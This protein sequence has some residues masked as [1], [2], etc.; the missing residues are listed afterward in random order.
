MG[1]TLEDI[2]RACGVSV[3]TVD[4]AMNNKPRISPTTKENILR[5]ANE[6]G[7]RPD[8]LARSLVKG[9]S[10]SIGVV[11]FEIRNRF[12]AQ[13]VN[14]IEMQAK[15][16][17]YFVYITLHEEDPALE[18]RLVNNLVDRR[19]DGIVICPVGKG[20]A[21][22]RFIEHLAV[23]VITI[24]NRISD[25]VPCVGIDEAAAAR[26]AARLILNRGYRNLVFV[27]PSLEN[28]E[29]ENLF[30]H[31][32]RLAG[33]LEAMSGCEDAR[34]SIIDHWDYLHHVQ[35]MIGQG[36]S[37]TAFFCS[38]DTFALEILKMARESGRSVPEDFGLMGFDGIDTLEYVTPSLATVAVP[39][40]KIGA[41]AVDLLLDQIEGR[42]FDSESL[43]PYH[44]VEGN[45]LKG[46]MSV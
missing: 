46:R 17:D 34:Y 33:F 12:F 19:I 14:A 5:T 30:S 23:P 13:L 45:S 22:D 8:L 42:V 31:E 26:D 1:V 18:T 2:A 7:Y 15:K 39:V 16:R 43:L 21:F 40:E 32:Q 36:A 41:R 35:V 44:L 3:G 38:G 20:A 28:R 4:R 27:C 29:R 9:R 10:M 24:G 25:K 11:V 37:D 6:M